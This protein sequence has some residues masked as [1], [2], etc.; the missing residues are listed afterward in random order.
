ME[1]LVRWGV[2]ALV[3]WCVGWPDQ[4]R[5]L[6]RRPSAAEILRYTVSFKLLVP[7][8][9]CQSGQSGRSGQSGQSEPLPAVIASG[10]DLGHRVRQALPDHRVDSQRD[11]GSKL[12]AS[13]GHRPDERADE[14]HALTVHRKVL[15][16]GGQHLPP[17]AGFMRSR[18]RISSWLNGTEPPTSPVLP[19]CGVTQMPCSKQYAST[20]ETC[21]VV[22]G[23]A[24][25][26]TSSVPY[27]S[28]QSLLLRSSA[29]SVTT[30]IERKYATSSSTTGRIVTRV[31]LV[32]T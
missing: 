13:L 28:I 25:Q 22:E 10:D 1:K 21:N 3:R 2:G 27:R 14:R 24:T 31:S 20:R 16:D 23:R 32:G 18:E 19:A 17:A 12:L 30:P 15:N 29:N 26:L 8:L 4:D 9:G 7:V 11:D 6:R 5:P